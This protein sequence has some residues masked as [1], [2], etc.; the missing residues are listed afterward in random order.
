MT[1]RARIAV[2]GAGIAG[3]ACAT[4]LSAL[5]VAVT[6]FDKGRGVGGRVATRRE[7]S[8]HFNHGAQYVTARGASFRALLDFLVADGAAAPWPAAGAGRWTGMPGMSALARHMAAESGAEMRLGQQVL[9]LR[10]DE[11]GWLLRAVPAK[12]AFP[13]EVLVEGGA[14][15]RGHGASSI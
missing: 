10:D 4:E 9:F 12:E 14:V 6:V 1:E 8:M 15:E 7:G 13:G 5:G 2:V 11:V 3:L